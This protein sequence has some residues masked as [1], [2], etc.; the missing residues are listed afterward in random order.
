MFTVKH[1]P[2]EVRKEDGSLNDFLR[3]NFAS[4]SQHDSHFNTYQS[5]GTNDNQKHAKDD[6]I[7]IHRSVRMSASYDGS[8]VNLF[9]LWN[10]SINGKNISFQLLRMD[11]KGNLV[12]QAGADSGK[13]IGQVKTS[14]FTDIDV[15]LDV[16]NNVFSVALDGVVVSKNNTLLTESVIND[17]KAHYGDTWTTGDY[18]P[19]EIRASFD[20]GRIPFS[21][22]TGYI[23][24]DNLY[25][26]C[27]ANLSDTNFCGINNNVKKNTWEQ[28]DEGYWRY[29]DEN[30]IAVTGTKEI[31]GKTYYFDGNGYFSTIERE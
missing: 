23:D 10:R 30:G 31:A 2:D 8:S 18:C 17:F 20:P 24:F 16:K 3:L 19:A 9:N 12:L 29:Y 26:Y 5:Y 11:D 4:P 14:A 13:V 22:G 27:G 7:V 21:Y 1:G 25:V 6:V 15:I 28:T